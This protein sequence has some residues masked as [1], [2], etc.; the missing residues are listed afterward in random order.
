VKKKPT[1]DMTGFRKETDSLGEVLVPSGAYFGAQ[2]QRAV[3]NFP[4]SGIR[5]PRR[6]L[7]ALGRIKRAAARANQELGLL[8][9]RLAEAIAQAATEVVDGKLDAHFVVDVFQTGSGT[10]TNMNA[11]EVIANRANEILGAPRGAKSPVHPNDMVN[12]GQSSNDVIPTA[13]HVASLQALEGDLLP[14]LRRLEKALA[15]KAEEFGGIV[16]IGRTHLQ[17]AT[18]IL[19]G[20]EFSGYASQVAHSI[21]RIESVRDPLGELA[22]GGTAIGTG[23]NTHP[24]FAALAIERLAGETGLSLREAGNHFEAQAAKDA[25]V[26]ASGALRSV[27]VSLWK[28]AQ[29]LRFLASGPRC[30]IGEIILPAT[31]PGSSIMP[32]KVNPVMAEALLQACA[33]VHGNDL[34]IVFAAQGSNFELNVMMPVMAHNFLQGVAILGK[35]VDLFTRKCV[36]GV[37]ADEKRCAELVEKSLA[38]VTPLALRIGYDRA[39]EIAKAAHATGRSIRQ[40]ALARKVLPEEELDRVLDPRRMTGP[41]GEGN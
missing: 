22:L 28:I 13:M 39:A 26:E 9:P 31:Q 15:A 6:F 38:L 27:A 2:T 29:D 37:R 23:I 32:G 18:P 1:D 3:E 36:E 10:S 33:Q 20:Q 16:K 5:F 8:S 34:A 21:R 24:R 4:V 40:V 30:G 25:M 41:P 7:E 19:L 14:P 11:N 17:D 35:A 12:R